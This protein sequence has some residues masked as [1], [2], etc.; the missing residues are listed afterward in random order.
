M[1]VHAPSAA[2]LPRRVLGRLRRLHPR[3]R[4]LQRVLQPAPSVG[5][6]D[7]GQHHGSASG[8][9]EDDRSQRQHLASIHLVSGEQASRGPVRKEPIVL[10]S[11]FSGPVEK[12]EKNRFIFVPLSF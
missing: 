10:V 3:P 1:A 9:Q 4:G 6:L 8:L 7:H 11:F 2:R 12:I 5:T